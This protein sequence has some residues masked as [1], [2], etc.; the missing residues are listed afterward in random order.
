MSV[1]TYR[2]GTGGAAGSQAMANY[3]QKETLAPEPGSMAAYYLGEAPPVART[4]IELYAERVNAG[5][6]A[7]TEALDL[8]METETAKPGFDY[9]TY[10]ALEERIG[11]EL[12]DAAIRAEFFE[13]THE[14]GG[15][16]AELRA[17]LS[18]S[19]AARLG[20]Q[21]PG[22]PLTTEGI[23]NLLNGRR[24]D[25]EAIEGRTER[26]GNKSVAE[27]FGLTGEDGPPQ[28]AALANILAGK[29]ADGAVSPLPES[30]VE[31]ARKRF[32]AIYGVSGREPAAAELANMTAGRLATGGHLNP[33]DW[34]RGVNAT[35]ERVTYIDLTFS[36]DKSLSIAWALAPT[37]AERALLLSA[38]RTSVAKTMAYIEQQHAWA[39]RGRAGQDGVAR[40][41]FA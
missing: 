2:T 37:E 17:G 18:P 8:L 10:D 16:V 6:L 25:G 9:D 22:R 41:E 1:L 3:L 12:A 19:M 30:V 26:S 39:R 21:D 5:D 28:G 7:Y 35:R 29:R 20:I 14:A 40:G 38:F 13:V 27:V 36:P 24:M 33:T 34:Q 11:T 15:T 23:A 31:G 4:T 32:L